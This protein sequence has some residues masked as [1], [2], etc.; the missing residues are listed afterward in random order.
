MSL[1]GNAMRDVWQENREAGLVMFEKNMAEVQ[2]CRK[3]SRRIDLFILLM[4]TVFFLFLL[5]S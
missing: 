1:D 3:W 4:W 5:V 2:R